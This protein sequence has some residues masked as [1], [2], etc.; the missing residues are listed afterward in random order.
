MPGLDSA[1]VALYMYSL[2]HTYGFPG[3]SRNRQMYGPIGLWV[4][5][6]SYSYVYSLCI[7]L[8]VLV[9]LPGRIEFAFRV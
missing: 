3:T 8:Q 4:S 9:L 1:E 5:F 7:Y 2:S 6:S